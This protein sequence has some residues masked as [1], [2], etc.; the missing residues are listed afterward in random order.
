M[1]VRMDDGTE[2]EGGPGDTAVIPPGH[3]AGEWEMNHVFHWILLEWGTTQRKLNKRTL[4]CLDYY[5]SNNWFQRQ[6]FLNPIDID[7]SFTVKKKIYLN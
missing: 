7:K 2:F 3:D 6:L 4:L 1:K 5:T